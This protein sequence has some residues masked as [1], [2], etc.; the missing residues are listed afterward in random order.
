MSATD[1]VETVEVLCHQ[2]FYRAA[3]VEE[4]G[5]KQR[6]REEARAGRSGTQ[7]LW[8]PFYGPVH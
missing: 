4:A 7:V 8:V 6:G 2:M 3:S 5:S 1:L